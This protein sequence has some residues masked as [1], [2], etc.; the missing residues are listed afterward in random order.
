MCDRNLGAKIQQH[1]ENSKEL[2]KLE[3]KLRYQMEKLKDHLNYGSGDQ[4]EGLLE[5]SRLRRR[6]Q[7]AAILRNTYNRRER[8]LERQMISILE[9]EENRQFNLYK[10]TLMRLVEDH[11]IV[12]DR[13]ADA[14]L[15]LRTLH[16]TN[17]VSC[18]S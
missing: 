3:T 13:I 12:E 11:R 15:Q 18:S 7:D 8:D 1:L 4:S 2:L 17:R 9:E 16:T 10:D 5:E 14:Q 6:L